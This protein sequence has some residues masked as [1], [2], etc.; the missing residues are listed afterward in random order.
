MPTIWIEVPELFLKIAADGVLGVKKAACELLIH[1]RNRRR[2]RR[3]VKAHIASREQWCC[4]GGQ[5]IQVRR[6][7]QKCETLRLRV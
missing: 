1:N 6:R 3:V 7:I 4:T 5:N 2:C